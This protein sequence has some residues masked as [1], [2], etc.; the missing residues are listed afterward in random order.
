MQLT[1]RLNLKGADTMAKDAVVTRMERQHA[2]LRALREKALKQ[3]QGHQDTEQFL[4]D[5]RNRCLDMTYLL[6]MD[7]R[8]ESDLPQIQQVLST[9]EKSN[10]LF[11][12]C[13]VLLSNIL[14]AGK[15]FGINGRVLVEDYLIPSELVS[16]AEALVLR[17]GENHGHR[18]ERVVQHYAAIK[19]EIDTAIDKA[20]IARY[21]E[22]T[23]ED[24]DT[25]SN[26]LGTALTFKTH[27]SYRK[28]R[29]FDF[30]V[31]LIDMSKLEKMIYSDEQSRDD[32]EAISYCLYFGY[33]G[34][35]DRRFTLRHLAR[36]QPDQS[37]VME[38]T[39]FTNANAFSDHCMYRNR[40]MTLKF[41]CVQQVYE[42]LS[43]A[44]I[45][46]A[47]ASTMVQ[48]REMQTLSRVTLGL[49]TKEKLIVE[50]IDRKYC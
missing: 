31:D 48:R 10:T 46:L 6:F 19:A 20:N 41:R 13:T 14:T 37:V 33:E 8:D 43:E 9:A 23:V 12:V 24:L 27:S 40:K 39:T 1:N 35:A 7:V 49:I 21:R 32:D 50:D 15:T 29:D 18:R 26:Y 17:D 47:T 45:R 28:D 38:I 5:L 16:V 4:L 30:L 42:Y 11:G 2:G 25:C 36:I 22:P 44:Q 34:Y 3:Q